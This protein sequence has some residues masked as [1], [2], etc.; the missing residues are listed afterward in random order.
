MADAL[1]HTPGICSSRATPE[2]AVCEAL[3]G[4]L[5]PQ[6][7]EWPEEDF[8][9]MIS[10]QPGISLRLARSPSVWITSGYPVIRREPMPSAGDHFRLLVTNP[11]CA[12]KRTSGLPTSQQPDIQIAF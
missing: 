12:F 10:G 5:R 2:V 11:S 9:R 1:Q 3:G 6:R 4:A 7:G 8:Q